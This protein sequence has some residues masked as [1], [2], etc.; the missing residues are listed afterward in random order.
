MRII[1]KYFHKKKGPLDIVALHN[2]AVAELR[3]INILNKE[4]FGL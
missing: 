4:A 1:M 3:G 2:E